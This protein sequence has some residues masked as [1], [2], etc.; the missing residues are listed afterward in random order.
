MRQTATLS[1]GKVD[2]PMAARATLAVP[3]IT[4]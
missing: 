1:G 2:W 3:K 4:G